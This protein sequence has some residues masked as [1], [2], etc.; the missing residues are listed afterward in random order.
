LVGEIHITLV[1]YFGYVS[2]PGIT[3]SYT[4]FS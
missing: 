4:I 3:R 1:V 2:A